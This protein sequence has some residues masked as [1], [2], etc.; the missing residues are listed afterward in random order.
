MLLLTLLAPTATAAA[1]QNPVRTPEGGYVEVTLGLG[2]TVHDQ[3]VTDCEGDNCR[4]RETVWGP[5]LRLSARPHDAVGIWVQGDLGTSEL[6]AADHSGWLVGADAGLHLAWP[7]EG[8][9]PAL[10]VQ[11]SWQRSPITGFDDAEST[12]KALRLEAALFAAWGDDA[13]GFVAYGGPAVRFWQAREVFVAEDDVTFGLKSWVPVGIVVGGEVVSD[14]LG[15]PWVERTPRLA[16]G[17][18]ARALDAWGLQAWVSL[19]Y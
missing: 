2:G 12:D 6:D 7:R 8:L 15:L 19:R 17:L 13:E 18:E 11:G 9:R 4:V 10:S 16:V 1:Y 5:D 3:D 14:M